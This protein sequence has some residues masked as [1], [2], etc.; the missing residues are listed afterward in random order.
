LVKGLWCEADDQGVFEWRPLTLKARIMPCD[1]VDVEAVLSELAEAQ[2][3]RAFE[4]D[5]KRYGAIRNFRKFQ[6][7]K[8]PTASYPLP[9]SLRQYVGL[10]PVV[11]RPQRGN[12][13]VSQDHPEMGQLWVLTPEHV[14]HT[15]PTC[16]EHGPPTCPTCGGKSPQMEDGGWRER[17]EKNHPPADSESVAARGGR[18]GEGI[19]GFEGKAVSLDAHG[20]AQCRAAYPHDDLLARLR[21]YDAKFAERG[22]QPPLSKVLAFLGQD[23]PRRRAPPVGTVV[24]R[25]ARSEAETAKVRRACVKAFVKT[26]HWNHSW[27][28]KP[29]QEEIR[30]C[31]AA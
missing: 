6:R 20:M 23:A 9:D 7:P 16:S 17:E 25:S 2:F 3:L 5:G 4:V 13:T 24:E 8:R 18:A 28:D 12:G 31:E 1:T 22:E 27:G 14:P 19:D 26:G 29:D 21:I 11:S 10:P 15:S 30:A